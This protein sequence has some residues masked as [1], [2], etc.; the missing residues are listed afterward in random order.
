VQVDSKATTVTETGELPARGTSAVEILMNDHKVIKSLLDR[1]TSDTNGDRKATLENLKSVLTIHNAT[2]ENLVYP[3]L[4]VVGRKKAESLS[5]YHETAEADT[6]VFELDMLLKESNDEQFAKGA[7]KLQ[8]AVL[9]HIDK[10]ETSAFPQLQEKA[11]AAQSKQLAHDVREFRN[12]IHMK[13]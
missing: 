6:V 9:E 13:S 2:E 7:K 3:A 8:A 10:E 1:L 11:N 4:A 12:T 5:L